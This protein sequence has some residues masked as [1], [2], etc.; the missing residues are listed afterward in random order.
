[1]LI[2]NK[3]EKP[4]VK[5]DIKCIFNIKIK[6]Q[7]QEVYFSTQKKKTENVFKNLRKVDQSKTKSKSKRT[8]KNNKCGE[9][10]S[11]FFFKKT[12]K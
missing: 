6:M 4:L 12:A 2:R 10:R 11:K 7:V 5:S 9:L 3:I 1:M 8:K